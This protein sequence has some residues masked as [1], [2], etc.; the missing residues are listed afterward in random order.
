VGRAWQAA[1]CMAVLLG[2]T[3]ASAA[4]VYEFR[5]GLRLESRYD[6]DPRV[7]TGGGGQ[8]L[9][10]VMPQVGLRMRDPTLTLEAGYAA[11]LLMRHG[12][13]TTTLD[14]HAWLRGHKELSRLLRL[15]LDGGL[16]R[17]TDPLSLPRESLGR[18]AEP[19][20]YGRLRVGAGARLSQRV[21]LRAGWLLEHARTLE[22]EQRSGG[23]SAP[24]AE[25]WWRASRRLSLGV[26]Y[27]YQAFTYGADTSHAHGGAAALSW[28]PGR[29][30]RL[31]ARAGPLLY[32]GR[33]GL[34]GLLPRASLELVRE[35][36]LELAVTAGHDLVGAS[37]LAD[38]VWADW[39]SVTLSR[40]LTSRLSAHAAAQAF[41]NGRPPSQ[42][43]LS[44]ESVASGYALAAAV[45]F[46][47][48]RYMALQGAVS[49]IAQVAS[50]ELASGVDLARNVFALR[51]VLTGG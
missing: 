17:V 39:L 10:K 28:Q 33:Q 18:P 25:A 20:L 36:P 8:L 42:G 37:G 31:T 50:A 38:A 48:Q 16:Y 27:R 26:E 51:L 30:W 35:G 3:G 32:T 46:R 43:W 2:A 24:S 9:S 12:S 23:L 29:M 13:G 1:A 5:P 7:T 34:Q 6:D 4:R 45:E 41:R 49:H 15:E 47:L 44:G 14:H 40:R 19:L 22:G 21:E 11:A